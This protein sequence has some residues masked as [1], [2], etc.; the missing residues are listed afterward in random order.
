MKN[1]FTEAQLK[2]IEALESGKYQQAK[3]GLRGYNGFCCLGVAAELSGKPY[4]GDCPAVPIDIIKH[5]LLRD[6]TGRA[7]NSLDHYQLTYLNDTLGKSFQEIAAILR[8]HP[9]QY[10]TN[11][12]VLNK[13][14]N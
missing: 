9:E 4:T 10:F 5:Y 11:F 2:W 7:K 8:K 6:G 13:E 14:R 1:K 3:N 12:E